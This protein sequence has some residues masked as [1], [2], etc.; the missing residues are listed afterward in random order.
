ME[1]YDV[2][3]QRRSIRAYKNDKIDDAILQRIA[4]AVQQAP[5]ACNKQPFKLLFVKDASMRS[6][7]CSVCKF[8][9]LAQAPVLAVMLSNEKEAWVRYEGNSAADIDASI[10]MEHMVLSAAAEGLGS[11]WICAFSRPELDKV[12]NIEKPFRT[13][14]V[15]PLGYADAPP[16]DFVRKELNKVIEIIG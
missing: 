15:S 14:A 10:A 9:F 16:R 5:T 2:I 3:R 1:F 12:L 13:F 4:L 11:C 8:P 7:I 6:K